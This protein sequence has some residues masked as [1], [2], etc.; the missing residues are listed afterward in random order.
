LSDPIIKAANTSVVLN[1]IVE[2][3]QF[4]IEELDEVE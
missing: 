2:N 4:F 1:A 3:R